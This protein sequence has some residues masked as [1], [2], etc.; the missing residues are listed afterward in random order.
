MSI[1]MLQ[2]PFYRK[3]TER[4]FANMKSTMTIS[5]QLSPF[6]SSCQSKYHSWDP[7][8]PSL[9][10]VKCTN[11]LR[12][13]QLTI[14]R[15]HS[16]TDS[17]EIFSR[18]NEAVSKCNFFQVSRWRVK[19][20][21]IFNIL[22]ENINAIMLFWRRNRSW[23]LIIFSLERTPSAFFRLGSENPSVLFCLLYYLKR[24]ANFALFFLF[25]F[26]NIFRQLTVRVSAVCHAS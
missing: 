20:D 19:T 24:Y 9:P 12:F 3:T 18:F 4:Q 11:L 21:L 14:G 15:R 7:V 23:W 26:L 16:A 25:E 13:L 6:L 10:T 8:R 22:K 2:I 17:H 1:L 5:V